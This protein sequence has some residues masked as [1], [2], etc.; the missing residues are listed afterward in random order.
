MSMVARSLA[1][2]FHVFTVDLRNHG[3]SFHHSSMTYLDMAKDILAF[4]DEKKMGTA[5]IVGHS[6]GG[7]C[8]MQTA[9]SF[10]HRVNRIV[11]VDIA[12]KIYEPHWETYLNAMLVLNFDFVKKRSDADKFLTEA[13]PNKVYRHFLL[14]NLERTTENFYE[15][16]SNLKALMENKNNICATVTGK[17]V[18]TNALF[19]KGGSSPF[20][21][22][23]DIDYI[24]KFFP[25]AKIKTISNAGHL[26][27][28]EAKEQFTNLLIEFLNED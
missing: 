22:D 14:Q 12:P 7:K 6:M 19:I 26:V 2:S 15:W 16:K 24:L 23:T 5:S 11:V 10:P 13:I 20:I 9:L 21:Q 3:D 1:N 4:M 27:H 8:A 18:S 25:A 17:P 28:F